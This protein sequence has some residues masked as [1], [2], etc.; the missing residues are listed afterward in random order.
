MS[1][2]P[3]ATDVAQLHL[4]AGNPPVSPCTSDGS[5]QCLVSLGGWGSLPGPA[6]SLSRKRPSHPW[7]R[8]SPPPALRT[9]SLA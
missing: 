8:T 4:S 3:A 7:M 2:P 1:P 5:R 9:M 6:V